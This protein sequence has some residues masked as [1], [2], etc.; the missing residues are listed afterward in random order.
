MREQNGGH[1]NMKAWKSTEQRGKGNIRFLWLSYLL[2]FVKTL[3]WKLK[4]IQVLGYQRGKL[5]N[6]LDPPGKSRPR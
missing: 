3:T 6:G 2:C 1:L 5:A 4:S